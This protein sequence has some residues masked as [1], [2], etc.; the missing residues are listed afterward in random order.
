MSMTDLANRSDVDTDARF[1]TSNV[2]KDR[3][4]RATRVAPP[5]QAKPPRDLPEDD[6]TPEQGARVGWHRRL[7]KNRFG[8]RHDTVEYDLPDGAGTL[9]RSSFDP[10]L[11]R[12]I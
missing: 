8:R 9:G 2:V 10:L 3:P 7:F 1:G 11:G 5:V 6:P 4:E 12:R